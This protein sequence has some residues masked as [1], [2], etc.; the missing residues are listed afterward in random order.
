[1]ADATK[2]TDAAIEA[3]DVGAAVAL[4]STAAA[5]DATALGLDIVAAAELG[6]NPVAGKFDVLKEAAV[7]DT[8]FDS[9]EI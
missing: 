4:D 2:A 1:M 8:K 5:A 7:D 3:A 9:H 6:L